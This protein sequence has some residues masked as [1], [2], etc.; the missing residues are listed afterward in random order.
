MTNRLKGK[1]ALITGATSGIGEA[2]AQQLA[3]AGAELILAARTEAKLLKLASEL[4]TNVTT[5][6]LDVRERE[7]VEKAFGDL[8]PDILINSAGLALG[9]EPLDEGSIEDWEQMID[10]NVKGLL[11]VSRVILTNMRKENKGHIVN[12]GSIAGRMAYPGGNVYCAT[13]AAVHSLTQSMNLDVVGTNIRVSNIA[14]GAVETNFSTIR[15]H[16]N[17]EKAAGVYDGYEPLRAEDI[18]DLTLYVLNA[19]AH[20][21]IQEALIMSTA[22][23]NPF[24]LHREK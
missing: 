19:P 7:S 9:L 2:C 16:G 3:E 14:P 12:L 21:N 8:C 5:I 17:E 15:F 20:V 1:T 24:V 10:T 13:K 11:Y 22:Q 6:T 4:P 18:A 23:R